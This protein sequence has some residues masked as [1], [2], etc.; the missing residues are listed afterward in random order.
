MSE[1]ITQEKLK[2]LYILR[3]LVDELEGRLETLR[4]EIR[5]LHGMGAEVEKGPFGLEVTSYREE[6][7]N[8]KMLV[9]AIAKVLGEDKARELKAEAT[10]VSEK[11]LVKVVL[12][13]GSR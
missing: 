10:K 3:H 13:E 4:Q 1:K 9:E 2:D 8:A 11:T 5:D 12:L 6:R 7:T